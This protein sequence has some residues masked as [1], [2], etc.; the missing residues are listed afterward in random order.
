MKT[1]I[2]FISRRGDNLAANGVRKTHILNYSI[3]SI[4]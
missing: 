1:K 4:K 3:A 2:N